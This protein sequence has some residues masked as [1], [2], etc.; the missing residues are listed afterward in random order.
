MQSHRV[1]PPGLHAAGMLQ[2]S[3]HERNNALSQVS[4]Q[5]YSSLAGRPVHMVPRT[6]ESVAGAKIL[7]RKPTGPSTM[8]V[9][10]ISVVCSLITSAVTSVALFYG[11]SGGNAGAASSFAAAA[12]SA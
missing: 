8:K 10:L 7:E 6:A 1:P 5:F 4:G 3:S 2:R 12:G 9:V 11:L